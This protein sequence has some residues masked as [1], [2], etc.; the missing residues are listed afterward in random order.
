VKARQL[1]HFPALTIPPLTPRGPLAIVP[2]RCANRFNGAHSI[3]EV[4]DDAARLGLDRRSWAMH[5]SGAGLQPPL[6]ENANRLSL[7]CGDQDSGP[8]EFSADGGSIRSAPV[9]TFHR[10]IREAYRPQGNDR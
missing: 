10:F 8:G 6:E 9:H 3:Y 7:I 1:A 5:Q 4:T 2:P